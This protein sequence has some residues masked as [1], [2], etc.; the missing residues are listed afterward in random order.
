MTAILASYPCSGS[1]LVRFL[2]E[3][4]TGNPTQGCLV[5]SADIPIYKN[6][7]PQNPNILEHV[8]PKKQTIAIKHHSFAEIRDNIKERNLKPSSL[9][10]LIR[11]PI[12][13]ISAHIADRGKNQSISQFK[14]EVQNEVEEYLDLVVFYETCPLKKEI[15]VYEKI[16]SLNVKLAS[17]EIQK[18]V[19]FFEE[20]IVIDKLIEVL[21]FYDDYLSVSAS[22]K[23]RGWRGYRSQGKKYYHLSK[24]DREKIGIILDVVK[25]NVKQKQ[26]DTF[27]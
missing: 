3:A 16:S 1:H 8:H 27:F 19:D 6:Q 23:G 21:S 2:I 5:N 11:D 22:G 17:S 10:L 12:D 25:E 14:Q 26:L 9:L 20:N 15:L 13:V 7:F 4:L 18:L 24:L